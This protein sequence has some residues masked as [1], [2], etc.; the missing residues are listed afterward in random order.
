VPGQAGTHDHAVALTAQAF[1]QGVPGWEHVTWAATDRAAVRAVAALHGDDV[2]LLTAGDLT[3]GT[4]DD[5]DELRVCAAITDA[6]EAEVLGLVLHRTDG[7]DDDAGNDVETAVLGVTLL[8]ETGLDAGWLAAAGAFAVLTGGG[9]LAAT[10]R[11]GE[12]A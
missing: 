8:A 3:T 9:V 2:T 12:V 5:V 1:E 6:E 7:G 11:R 10:R 4:L